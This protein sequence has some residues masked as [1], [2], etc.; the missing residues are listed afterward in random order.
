MCKTKGCDFVFEFDEVGENMFRLHK[1]HAVHSCGD[2]LA[3][4]QLVF[5]KNRKKIIDMKET[6]YKMMKQRCYKYGFERP[7]VKYILTKVL[8]TI[9]ANQFENSSSDLLYGDVE[10]LEDRRRIKKKF[11]NLVGELKTKILNE[12]PRL[13]AKHL[14][15]K[16]DSKKKKPHLKKR[17]T[18]VDMSDKDT[19][20]KII[21]RTKKLRKKRS[22][23]RNEDSDEEEDD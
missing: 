20:E 15:E 22:A 2:F 10:N 6:L 19:P 7:K 16:K 11:D 4:D 12:D 18:G 14:S 1:S 17:L 3:S 13:K 21:P 5:F 23:Q 9:I 8:L